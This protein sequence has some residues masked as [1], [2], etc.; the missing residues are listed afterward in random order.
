MRTNKC[1]RASCLRFILNYRVG[2]WI[3]F[4]YPMV[5]ICIFIIPYT[6]YSTDEIPCMYDDKYLK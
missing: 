1:I 4:Y 3:L 6:K 5:N 2:N